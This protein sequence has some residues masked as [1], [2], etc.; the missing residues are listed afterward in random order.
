MHATDTLHIE[1]Q[2]TLQLGGGPESRRIYLALACDHRLAAKARYVVQTFCTVLDREL[3][4]LEPGQFSTL[5]GPLDGPVVWYGPRQQAPEPAPGTVILHAAPAA[6]PFFQSSKPTTPLDLRFV[7]WEQ[8]PVPFLF[9]QSAPPAESLEQ[10]LA[11]GAGVALPLDL[12]ASAFYFLSSWEETV[13]PQRDVHGRFLHRFARAPQLG[14]EGNI[15]DRYLDLFVE[16]LNRAGRGL[17][18]PVRIPDWDG[19]PFVA[20]LT[21]DVDGIRKKLASRLR[22]AGK[23]LLRPEPGHRGTPLAQRLAYATRVLL[24]QGDS[25]FTFPD[26]FRWEQAQGFTA[27]YFFQAG[28]ERGE[29]NYLLRDPLVQPFIA[30]LLEAGFEVGLHG[31]YRAAFDR[32]QLFWEKEALAQVMGGPPQGHR[33]HYLRLEYTRTLPLYEEAGFLY[34][35]TLGYADHE[36]YRNQFSYPYHPYH[37]G[38]DRPLAFLELPTVIMDVTLG[39]YRGLP[40]EEGW[41][42]TQAW[43]E[44]IKA[45]RGCINLLW[46]NVW[47]GEYP[48][49][50]QLYAR[51][52]DWIQENGGRGLAGRDVLALWQKRGRHV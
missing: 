16:L 22:F 42:V 46:H 21:H 7:P 31:T 43:L 39:G 11:G 20:C 2:G 32:E 8:K 3:H 18:Q 19:A 45:R 12:L 13:N 49:Y 47:D 27:T 5:A 51:A 40:V 38:E 23:H 37:H 15:V 33:N 25:Y 1:S 52:L 36:G 48:G 4:L 24:R 9:T 26:F 30:Q 6:A 14:L 34:D 35:A 28:G 29:S 17:W 41:A 10:L 50:F 44:R